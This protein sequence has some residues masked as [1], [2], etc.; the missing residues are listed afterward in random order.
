[1]IKRKFVIYLILHLI[2]MLYSMSGIL[3]KLASAEKFLSFHFCLYYGGMILLLVLYAFVWQ[4]IIKYLPLTTAF[5]NKAVTVVWG[6]VWGLM[7]F[8][9]EL[10]I[11]KIIGALLVVCG[12]AL[13]ALDDNRGERVH[14]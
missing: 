2:L 6:M 1:M 8:N 7:V 13:Y 12:V 11:G 10:T 14:G 4:Q 9:E 3:S 5:A